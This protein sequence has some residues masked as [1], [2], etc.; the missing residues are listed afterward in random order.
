MNARAVAAALLKG[1]HALLETLLPQVQPSQLLLRAALQSKDARCVSQVLRHGST[2]FPAG[3]YNEETVRLLQAALV[4]AAPPV[5]A[6]FLA[7]LPIDLIRRQAAS[8]VS[9]NLVATPKRFGRLE[10]ANAL[11]AF[12][13]LARTLPGQVAEV[14][15][16]YPHLRA[17]LSASNIWRE[18]ISHWRDHAQAGAMFAALRAKRTLS[19]QCAH[20]SFVSL[21]EAGA[22]PTGATFALDYL[23]ETTFD[24]A[25]GELRFGAQ[26]SFPGFWKPMSVAGFERFLAMAASHPMGDVLRTHFAVWG[27]LHAMQGSSSMRAWQAFSKVAHPPLSPGLVVQV[28]EK[29]DWAGV[30]T[31]LDAG[32]SPDYNVG[33]REPCAFI[34]RVI[35][36]MPEHDIRPFVAGMEGRNAFDGE[37]GVQ[38]LDSLRR[39]VGAAKLVALRAALQSATLERKITPVPASP[40]SRM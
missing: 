15:E 34:Q 7:E 36:R 12:T 20:A 27:F 9:A 2:P 11:F 4:D 29:A 26:G 24:P 17:G 6:A 23:H 10:H 1:D 3:A 22:S 38:I 5:R 13:S 39:R 33:E 37:S 30:R 32:I 16:D 8:A 40:R 25:T 28:A 14:F 35:T 19:L 31:L 21:F 18:C